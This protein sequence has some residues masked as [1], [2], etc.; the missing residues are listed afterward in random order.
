MPIPYSRLTHSELMN[1]T[2][3]G[4]SSQRAVTLLKKVSVSRAFKTTVAARNLPED[5]S[6]TSSPPHRRTALSSPPNSANPPTERAKLLDATRS[7]LATLSQS[8]PQTSLLQTGI[9]ALM[10]LIQVK[11]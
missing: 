4:L 1:L 11:L 8:S 10:E 6:K 9:E 2:R 7:L 3:R 5:F